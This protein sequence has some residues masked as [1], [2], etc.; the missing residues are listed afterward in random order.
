MSGV[1]HGPCDE[2]AI[3]SQRA[4]PG[5]VTVRKRWVLAAAVLASTMA[6]T[7]ESVVNVALPRIQSDLGTTLPAMQWVVNAYTLCLSA[8]VLIGGAAVDHYGRRRMF[9]VGIAVFGGASIACG[10]A[11]HVGVLIA[12]RAIQGF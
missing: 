12:A 7:D 5:G 10:F 3:R 6:I 11:P 2:V 9:L 1:R 8:L 4:A